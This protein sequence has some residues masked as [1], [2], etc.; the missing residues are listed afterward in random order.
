MLVDVNEETSTK[1][2]ESRLRENTAP[3]SI[4]EEVGFL[5]R[6]MDVA[7]DALRI[8]LRKRK[9]LKL[10]VGAQVGKAFGPDEKAR[11][12]KCAREARSPH[13]YPALMLALNAGMRDA[14]MK[15]LTWAQINFEKRYLAV[16]QS[17]TEAGEGRTIPLNSVLNEALAAYAEWYALR[18]GEVRP[19][20]YVF[21]FGKPRPSDRARPVTTLKTAWRNLREKAKVSGRWHDNRHTL[22]TE[23]AESGAGEQTIMD[24]AGH[25]SKQMLKYSHV[26]MEAKRAAL[27]SIVR[28]P[29]ADAPEGGSPQKSPQST[30]SPSTARHAAPESIVSNP[31]AN[32]SD[33]ERKHPS[34]PTVTRQIEGQYPQKSPQSGNLG[35]SGV[36]KKGRKLLK[37][38]GSASA[39]LQEIGGPGTP[40]GVR[41]PL[42]HSAVR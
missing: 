37:G 40:I 8:R 7:G 19:E 28:K 14:E 4:N 34:V 3:K 20:W 26:R 13:I 23:L 32:A 22:I 30:A 11:L 18:F 16:L 17:K 24:I 35:R 25:V 29:T 27:E 1:Y 41:K 36:G 39:T 2:Q 12:I 6:M 21:P 5:L 33:A 15:T 9:M 10:K 38:I 31:A 42:I